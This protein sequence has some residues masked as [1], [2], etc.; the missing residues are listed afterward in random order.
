MGIGC[1]V[2]AGGAEHRR[3]GPADGLQHR[4]VGAAATEFGKLVGLAFGQVGV[5]LLQ[6]FA[7]VLLELR[8]RQLADAGQQTVLQAERRGL[9]DEVTRHLVGL[10]VRLTGDGLQRLGDPRL[11][12]AGTVRG[13]RVFGGHHDRQ[14]V[15]LGAVAVDVDLV[16]QRAVAE[17]GLQLGQGDE[18]ALRELQHVV[19]PVDIHQPVGRGLREDVAGPVVAVVVEH[20]RGGFGPLVV[21]GEHVGCLE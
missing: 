18:L 10:Q 3:G 14:Q 1:Q 19:A 21:T 4:R 6:A 16:D 8:P 7:V 13:H 5:E 11:E 17:L 2:G 20:A 12:R 15:G 9:D